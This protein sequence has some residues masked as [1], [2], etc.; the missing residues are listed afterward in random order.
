[1]TLLSTHR[2]CAVDTN[3]GSLQAPRYRKTYTLAISAARSDAETC[4]W[5][6]RQVIF[7]LLGIFASYGPLSGCDRGDHPQQV[8][9]AVPEFVVTDSQRTVDMSKLRGKVV[10]LNFWASWC[11]PC[12]E[13]LPSLQA[14]QHALPQ[15]LVLAV[16]T[17]D[18]SGAYQRFLMQH[19]VE[20]LSVQDATQTSNALYGTH[21]FPETYVID[22][23]G[24]VR[25]KYI[26]PQQ[27]TNFAIMDSLKQLA[28]E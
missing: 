6:R 26:G 24:I 18:D 19:H 27:F 21:R 28:A 4:R 11:P 8:G 10:V 12:L 15:V 20:L 17:D 9:K 22:K 23:N 25:Q 2:C 14:M 3:V 7:A 1:M 5:G 13:E 16:S